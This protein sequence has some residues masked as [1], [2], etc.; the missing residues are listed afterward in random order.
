MGQMFFI[1][2]TWKVV[3]LPTDRSVSMQVDI[4]IPGKPPSCSVLRKKHPYRDIRNL[5]KFMWERPEF[6][7]I[8][9]SPVSGITAA[10]S[11][12]SNKYCRLVWGCFRSGE[13]DIGAGVA[14]HPVCLGWRLVCPLQSGTVSKHR[15]LIGRAQNA[16]LPTPTTP[17]AAET[18]RSDSISKRGS[19]KTAD[20]WLSLN[21]GQVRSGGLP[22]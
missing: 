12:P 7:V 18:L 10:L 8:T 22:I 19:L 14:N 21:L 3:Y 15:L 5:D 1:L 6:R 20:P 4:T 16:A 13:S 17:R 9:I 2:F 11:R